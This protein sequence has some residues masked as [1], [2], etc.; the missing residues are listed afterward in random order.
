VYKTENHLNLLLEYCIGKNIFKDYYII[1]GSISKL[2]ETY[3]TLSE[4]IIRKYTSQILEGLEY[5][6]A[7]N[8]IHRGISNKEIILFIN[9]YI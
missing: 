8:I 7:H 5:L 1:G 9:N 6:H 3:K 2:L 4:N